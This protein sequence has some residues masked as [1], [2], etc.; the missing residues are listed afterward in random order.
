M[1]V[2]T[3]ALACFRVA[4]P[5][6]TVKVR[7][8][9][10]HAD[11][12]R[13]WR[14]TCRASMA[15]GEVLR[16]FF[17]PYARGAV[18]EIVLRLDCLDVEHVTHESMHAVLHSVRRAGVSTLPLN[19]DEQEERIVTVAGKLAHRITRELARRGYACA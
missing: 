12:R 3:R 6:E 5:W 15:R 19:D 4:I 13:T 8:V 11:L 14:S 16:A 9:A 18:G 17:V 7:L 1:A 10:T 2:V